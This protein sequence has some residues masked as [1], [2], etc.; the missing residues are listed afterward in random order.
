[1][2]RDFHET[3]VPRLRGKDQDGVR[4]SAL[5]SDR[6]YHK[7]LHLVFIPVRGFVDARAKVLSEGLR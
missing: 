3:K 5:R 6:L 2:P 1:M 4:L 7:K